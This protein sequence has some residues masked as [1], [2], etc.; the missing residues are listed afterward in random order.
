MYYPN[1]IIKEH[2]PTGKCYYT[3]SFSH[4]FELRNDTVFFAYSMPY[5]YTEMQSMLDSYELNPERNQFIHR[6]N[7]CRSLGG[8]N[9]DYLTITNKGTL[10]EIRAKR[11]VVIS[12]RVHPGETVGS[13]MMLGLFDEQ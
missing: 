2:S 12:A 5:T 8:N 3:L 9:C 11:A 10:E 6:K 13:W 7:M 1:G 4:T